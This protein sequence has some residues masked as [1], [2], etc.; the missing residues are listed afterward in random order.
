MQGPDRRRRHRRRDQGA[1]VWS[2]R[3]RPLP[4]RDVA[5]LSAIPG[6]DGVEVR[7]DPVLVHGQDTD[8]VARHLFTHTD[9]RDLEITSRGLEDAFIALTGRRRARS[10]SDRR[11]PGRPTTRRVPPV[12][13]IQQH[14]SRPRAAP[15]AAQPAHDDLHSWS[16]RPSSSCLRPDTRAGPTS[17]GNGNVSAYVALHGP[18]RR[19][20]IAP[21][22]AARWCG[23]AGARVEPPASAHPVAPERL[24]LRQGARRDG[25]DGARDRGRQRR[26]PGEG[27]RRCRRRLGRRP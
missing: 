15:D 24:H 6:V 10:S 4:Q 19:E 17:A 22:P 12:R 25:M 14:P 13:R 21:P 20:L 5:T 26:R 9:A 2:H 1:G 3:P 27:S 16:C 11:P 23:R 7:G 8:A 18:V